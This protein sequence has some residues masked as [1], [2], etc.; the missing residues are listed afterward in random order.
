MGARIRKEGDTWIIDGVGNG[1]LLAPEAPL[2][3]GNARHRLPA[4]DGPWSASMIS[5][6]LSSAMPR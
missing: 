6:P 1:A 4:D 3:F 2:D 5:I